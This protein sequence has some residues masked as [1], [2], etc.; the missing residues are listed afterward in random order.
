LELCVELSVEL[1]VGN[2][3]ELLSP[4]NITL[5]E[6]LVMMQSIYPVLGQESRKVGTQFGRFCN[7]VPFSPQFVRVKKEK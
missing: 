2:I 6:V 4:K 7:C 1:V 5:V 3:M